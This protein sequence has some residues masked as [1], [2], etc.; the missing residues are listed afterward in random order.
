MAVLEYPFCRAKHRS[1]KVRIL[2]H[3]FFYPCIAEGL[4]KRFSIIVTHK[5]SFRDVKNILK[6]QI[7]QRLDAETEGP[8]RK[9]V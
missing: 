2:F 4:E 6:R 7:N 1:S 9:G 8:V 3:F 5:N